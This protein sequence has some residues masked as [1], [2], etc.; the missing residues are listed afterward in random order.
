MSS[1][2]DRLA[3]RLDTT[4]DRARQRLRTLL[5]ALRS[6]IERNGEASLPGLGTFSREGGAWT[7]VPEET[8]V[9]SV[10]RSFHGLDPISVPAPEASAGGPLSSEPTRGESP[11]KTAPPAASATEEG[12]HSSEDDLFEA[13]SFE[14]SSSE[15]PAAESAA[16]PG[17]PE[18]KEEA[19]EET[20]PSPFAPDSAAAGSEASD[21]S[22]PSASS[23]Q[24]FEA[25]HGDSGSTWRYAALPAGF[26]V[27]RR[28]ISPSPEAV[29]A[30]RLEAPAS[31]PGRSAARRA[32]DRPREAH[33]LEEAPADEASAGDAAARERPAAASSS[34]GSGL[35]GWL[36]VLVVLL[37]GGVGAWFLFGQQGSED[38]TSPE[39]SPAATASGARAGTT[40]TDSAAQD[41]AAQDFAAQD[42]ADASPSPSEEAARAYAQAERLD[43]AEGGWTV[44]VASETTRDSARRTA[45][46]FARQFQDQ[47]YPVDVLEATVDGTPRY[48]V[49]VGQFSS[50]EAA[51]QSL[52][53]R[54]GRFPPGAW[55]LRVEP[56]S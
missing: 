38:G 3:R 29:R 9:R 14:G 26:F 42:T 21:W 19:G 13:I 40:A 45:Q 27:H 12:S 55:N 7:F 51:S 35:A 24:A 5:T 23:T 43:R 49:V 17:T 34:S 25:S 1:L 22:L 54:S 46:Q 36:A 16:S 2:I 44:V 50:R 8:L 15:E 18:Q 56:G 4:P 48:R 41:T 30:G 53:Q 31:A 37:A 6:R 52:Q 39:A 10:N 20:A 47:D 32:E 28:A 33:R 11:P